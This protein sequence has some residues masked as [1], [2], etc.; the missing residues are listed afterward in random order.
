MTSYIAVTSREWFKYLSHM[1]INENDQVNFWRKNK[2]PLNKI[3]T[4]DDFYFLVKNQKEVKEERKIL[5]KAR[6]VRFE[7]N[8]YIEAWNKY[9]KLNGCETSD[10]FKRNMKKIYNESI[11]TEFGC[12]ILDNF[13]VFN[14]GVKL[15]DLDIEFKN[16]IVSGKYIDEEDRNKLDYFSYKES[17]YIDLIQEVTET[18]IE[19]DQKIITHIVRE[20][21]PSLKKA[22]VQ[23]FL[24]NHT[25]LFCEV[26]GFDFNK[27]Y[28]SLGQSFIECHHT[29]PIHQLKE[30]TETQIEEMALLCANC[31]RM[32]HRKKEMLSI[33]ELKA[34]VRENCQKDKLNRR[35]PDIQ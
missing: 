8:S 10:E 6:F 19:G 16:S 25:H 2:A 12:I 7:Q 18:Y 4:G 23:K 34:I 3:E 5:G 28:G 31:H 26:C 14:T 1:N 32:I 21:N 13:E 15:S 30:R 27:Q 29:K 22:V 24:K 33:E 17:D 9:K 35:F 11:N 20:R